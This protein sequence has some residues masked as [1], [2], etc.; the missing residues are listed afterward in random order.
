[1]L[2]QPDLKLWYRQPATVWTEALPIGNGRLGAMVFG[3]VHEELI[4]LNES[5]LWSGGPVAK[6]VNPRAFEMLPRIRQALF[7]GDFAKGSELTRKMQ[8]LYSESYLPLG[9]LM[10]K[11]DFG[12]REPGEY[13]RD[14][15]ISDAIATTRF[16]IDGVEY[17]REIFASAP[18]GVIVMRFSAG[19]PRSLNLTI[20]ASSILQ[21]PQ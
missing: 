1:M 5:T 2:A 14:L 11:Q 4:Q 19:K 16:T 8:G 10:I 20:S 17:G 13:Y 18:G 12:G 7:A 21:A 15:N 9:D 3:G 6:N